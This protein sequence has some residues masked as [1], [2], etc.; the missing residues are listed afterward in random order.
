MAEAPSPRLFDIPALVEYLRSIGLNGVSAYTV[1]TE[2]NAGRLAHTKFGKKFYV[3]KTAID[4][5]LARAERRTR[6]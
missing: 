4:A 1:R 3:S 2:I 6:Q 5:W